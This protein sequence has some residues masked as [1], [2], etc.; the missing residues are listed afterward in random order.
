MQLLE[1]GKRGQ[2]R[3]DVADVTLRQRAQ[4]KDVAILRHRDQERL[5]CPQAFSEPPLRYEAAQ[6]LNLKFHRRG[7]AHRWACIRHQG[8][9][10]GRA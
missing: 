6:A 2:S 10:Q 1:S 7:M 8:P 9:T 5:G 4:V 3:R